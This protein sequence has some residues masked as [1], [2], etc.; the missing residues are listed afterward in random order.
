[1]DLGT[2]IKKYEQCSDITLLPRG[3]IVIRVDGKSFH[4]FTKGMEKPFDQKFID[5]MVNTG[6]RCSRKMQGFKMGYHQSDEFT[7]ILSDMDSY[8]TEMWHFPA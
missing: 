2:R 8:E 6:I 1:M 5:A 7:F 3:Y 4:T